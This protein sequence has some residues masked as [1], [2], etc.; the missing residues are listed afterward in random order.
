MSEPLFLHITDAH[1]TG[2]G[3]PLPLDDHKTKIPKINQDT[4]ESALRRLLSRLAER[5]DGEGRHLD[6]V[7]FT[8]DAAERGNLAGHAALRNII[9]ETLAKVGIVAEKIVATPGNHDVPRGTD[10]GSAERYASFIAAWR[11]AGCVTPWLDGIDDEQSLADRHR[12]IGP[13]NTWAIFPI[14]SAN[15]SHTTSLLQSPLKEIWEQIPKLVKDAERA[16]LTRQLE[17]LIRFD[18]AR[19]SP[20]QLEMLRTIINTTPGPT[21]GEQIRVAA[22]HHHLRTPSLHEEVKP[23]ADFTNLE[24]L[25]QTLRD[26]RI[27]VVLHGH[28][29]QRAAQRELIYDTRGENPRRT[30]IVSGGSFDERDNA[31]AVR[32]LKLEGLPWTPAAQISRFSLLRSGT[33]LQSEDDKPIPLWRPIETDT[34][35]ITLQGND[36]DTVYH[37]ACELA[38]KDSTLIIDLDLPNAAPAGIPSE[39]PAPSSLEGPARN[40]WF[41]EL[42]GWWQERHSRLENRVPYHHGSRLHR[43][44]GVLDQVGRVTALLKRKASSRA[45]AMLIDPM[46]DFRPDGSDEENFASFCLVQFRKRDVG[47][48]KYVVDAIAYYRAQEFR[49]W[50]PINVAELRALQI[51]ICAGS[52]MT[53]GRITTVTADARA[54]GRKPTEVSVPIIDRWLD[55]HPGRL[56]LL[57]AHL[58]GNAGSETSANREEVVNGWMQSLEEFEEATKEYNADGVPLAIEGLQ[59]LASYIEALEPIDG[60]LRDFLTSL[61]GLENANRTYESSKKQAADF[62]RWGALPHIQQLRD[63]SGKLL[64]MT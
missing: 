49:R 45:I 64:G 47:N 1:I 18:M 37:R 61:R 28:K 38:R 55:Q 51:C 3:V 5:L 17:G 9:L 48:G 7:I 50:W 20:E 25:R 32:T 58:S 21:T 24:L 29:H 62:A 36:L 40:R 33:E 22:I 14:N 56:F 43:Y 35:S 31:D 2:D 46:R 8:G 57:A 41:D 59:A 26:R 19:V 34:G 30:L 6:A 63:R 12:L 4:R 27:D 16:E 42:A 53:P 54:S 52:P 15:W 10:P 44:G 39:Y 13:G 60:N 23:F 11:D